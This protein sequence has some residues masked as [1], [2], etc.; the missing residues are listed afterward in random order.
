MTATTI[1]RIRIDRAAA[2]YGGDNND[3]DDGGNIMSK[4]VIFRFDN[5]I[6]SYA[7]SIAHHYRRI[8]YSVKAN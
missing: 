4:K 3:N 8:V 5:I 7:F 6:K 2:T 1:C